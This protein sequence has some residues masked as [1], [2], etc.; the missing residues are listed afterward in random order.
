MRKCD[1]HRNFEVGVSTV[2]TRCEFTRHICTTKSIQC[3]CHQTCVL[4]HDAT[5][6]RPLLHYWPT[7]TLARITIVVQ[8][9]SGGDRLALLWFVKR[10]SDFFPVLHNP[11]HDAFI[12]APYFVS[13]NTIWNEAESASSVMKGWLSLMYYWDAC[14]SDYIGDEEKNAHDDVDEPNCSADSHLWI[15]DG[16]GDSLS[17]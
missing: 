5:L 12:G 14:P 6:E 11:C 10:F 1:V 3:R 8:S 17:L 2:L 7:F 9:H 13:C 4:P 16:W 15:V